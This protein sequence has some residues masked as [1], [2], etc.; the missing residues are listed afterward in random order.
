MSL[1]AQG[2]GGGIGWLHW[3]IG[4][5]QYR[6]TVLQVHGRKINSRVQGTI[7]GGIGWTE[8]FGWRSSIPNRTERLKNGKK[9]GSCRLP[10]F[11]SRADSAVCHSL[12]HFLISSAKAGHTHCPSKT[13]TTGRPRQIGTKTERTCRRRHLNTEANCSH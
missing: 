1:L 2:G 3:G 7:D 6:T 10:P 5:W 4:W 9:D 12:P 13:K 8:R 11:I